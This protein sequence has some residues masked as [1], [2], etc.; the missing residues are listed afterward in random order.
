MY[1]SVNSQQQ[2]VNSAS[3]P[4]SQAVGSASQSGSPESAKAKAG[5]GRPPGLSALGPCPRAG[6]PQVMAA[7]MLG[8]R[9]KMIIAKQQSVTLAMALAQAAV[10]SEVYLQRCLGVA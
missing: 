5:Q 1:S 4:A 8:H 3:R 9:P 7:Y 6:R 10:S 2:L